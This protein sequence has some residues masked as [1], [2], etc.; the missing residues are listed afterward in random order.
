MNIEKMFFV[1]WLDAVLCG[2]FF[3]YNRNLQPGAVNILMAVAYQSLMYAY[4]AG[5]YLELWDSRSI[6]GMSHYEHGN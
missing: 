4:L 3:G 6:I 2:T 1:D 5:S